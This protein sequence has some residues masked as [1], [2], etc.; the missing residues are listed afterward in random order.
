M[1]VSYLEKYALPKLYK[2]V[3]F[4]Q[5]FQLKAGFN[6]SNTQDASI[7]CNVRT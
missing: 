6:S 2:Y 1:R 7:L 3:T 4:D 5:R